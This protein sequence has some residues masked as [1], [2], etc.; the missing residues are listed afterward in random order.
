MRT[1]A[2]KAAVKAPAKS[3]APA[4][5]ATKAV[6]AAKTPAKTAAALKPIKSGFTKVSLIK[7]LAEQ[8]SADVK[9]VKSIVAALE[10]TIL[11]AIHKR[12]AG[13]FTLPGLLKISTQKVPA[14]KKGVR[15]DPFTGLER[16]FPAKPA[17]VRV[18]ARALK[19]LKD[20]AI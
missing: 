8:A 17:S 2:K 3:A 9:I 14:R 7:H 11:G 19:K 13:E 18:K 6:K 10:D 5:A 20:A 15:K 16:E 1:A 4:K 12:G